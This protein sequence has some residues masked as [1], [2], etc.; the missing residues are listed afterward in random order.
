MGAAWRSGSGGIK[1][2]GRSDHPTTLLLFSIRMP[3]GPDP[4]LEPCS[5]LVHTYLVGQKHDYPSAAAAG[6]RESA[7]YDYYLS[8]TSLQ[9]R[10][11]TRYCCRERIIGWNV[12]V[13]R[14]VPPDLVTVLRI[15]ML[16]IIAFICCVSFSYA[17]YRFQLTF[18]PPVPVILVAV[19]AAVVWQ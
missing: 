4:P 5:R 7:T 3:P 15:N 10:I 9:Y 12:T 14:Y 11:P 6:G 16:C 8:K 19:A 18:K 2:G 13:R 17:M 1:S